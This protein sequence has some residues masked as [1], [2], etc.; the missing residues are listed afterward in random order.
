LLQEDFITCPS[1]L[2]PADIFP[3]ESDD[4]RIIQTPQVGKLS[5][6]LLINPVY[7]SSGQEFDRLGI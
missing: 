4:L 2:D 1:K 3:F 7:P 6:L 5:F